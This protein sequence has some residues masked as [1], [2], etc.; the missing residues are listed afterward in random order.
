M[1]FGAL[2]TV[3]FFV[4]FWW[5]RW[6]TCFI[7]CWY[8][9]IFNCTNFCFAQFRCSDCQGQSGAKKYHIARLWRFRFLRAALCISVTVRMVFCCLF[10]QELQMKRKTNDQ[11]LKAC[12]R[13]SSR[14]H[15]GGS[16][17]MLFVL[18]GS[19]GHFGNLIDGIWKYVSK[20]LLEGFLDVVLGCED[21]LSKKHT[22]V[23]LSSDIFEQTTTNWMSCF[24]SH[25]WK[26]IANRIS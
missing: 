12:P 24:P 4:P 18:V 17:C 25:F 26:D 2:K 7:W 10:A 13:M 15:L 5:G 21:T 19:C 20:R 11:S 3:A 8:V 22:F 14:K 23:L 6:S 1:V 16:M 9:F